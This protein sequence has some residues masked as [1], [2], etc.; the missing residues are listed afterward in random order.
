MTIWEFTHYMDPHNQNHCRACVRLYNDYRRYLQQSRSEPREINTPPPRLKSD[1][2]EKLLPPVLFW[3]NSPVV[4]GETL[5]LAKAGAC[6]LPCMVTLSPVGGASDDGFAP[7]SVFLT[8][9]QVNNASIMV[10]LPTGLPLGAYSVTAAGSAPMIVNAP[11]LWWT[12][13]DAGNTSTPGGWLRVFGNGISLAG[14][15]SSAPYDDTS[16]RIRAKA[17]AEA[18]RLAAM[19]GDFAEI[20]VLAAEQLAEAQSAVQRSASVNRPYLV[21]TDAVSGKLIAPITAH[22]FSTVEAMFL[23]PANTGIDVGE[24]SV[25]VSNGYATTGL[26]AFISP[27]RPHQR[28]ITVVSQAS[29]RFDPTRFVVSDYNGCTGGVGSHNTTTPPGKPINCSAALKAALHAAGANGGG[30][31]FFG[32]GRWFVDSP[33]LLPHGV[34]LKGAGM[35]LTT[36][37]L[38]E[39]NISTAP[40][41]EIATAVNPKCHTQRE[42]LTFTLR[43]T[44][45][46]LM[47]RPVD[48]LSF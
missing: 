30:T 4:P 1:D 17:R 26:N 11:E 45:F 39:H 46:T 8:P 35:G 23:L 36:I 37:F 48:V 21:L 42:S 7:D 24:Y 14:N 43:S 19:R 34:L 32:P 16:L 38:S 18:M 29:V 6:P 44:V 2:S 13:G 40:P 15:T 41:A 9:A 10:L 28:T 12:N 25:K 27:E 31:V 20:T 3:S 33:V 47:F 22:N 5:L